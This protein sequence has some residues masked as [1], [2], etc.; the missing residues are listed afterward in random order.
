[1]GGLM[2][3]IIPR[4]SPVPSVREQV[5]TTNENGQTAIKIKIIQGERESSSDNNELGEFVLSDLE[6]KPAG[7]PRI[8]VRFSL[9]ADGILF[10]SASEESSGK[11]KNL[12]IKTNSDL[13]IQ[14]MR[15]IVESSIKNAKK[16]I[17]LRL[18]I[19]AKIKA[20]KAINEIKNV[21]N[22]MK[23]LCSKNEIIEINKIIKMMKIE[24]NSDNK[25]KIIKLVEQL[26]EKTKGF[27]EKIINS[28]F[29][30]FVGKKI[31]SI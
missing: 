15:L 11:E 21:E 23:K 5:F 30:N 29:S 4:N 22:M 27:A 25:E 7:I 9:D 19:E 2:E 20:Q 26:N 28:N 18:L 14:E 3:K 10:V 6:P 16:D 1:M 12:A 17:D 24:L 13:S 8:N 31:D